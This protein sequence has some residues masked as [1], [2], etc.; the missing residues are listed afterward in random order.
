MLCSLLCSAVCCVVCAVWCVVCACYTYVL[1]SLCSMVCAVYIPQKYENVIFSLCC[2]VLC[3]VCVNVGSDVLTLPSRYLSA[4]WGQGIYYMLCCYVCMYMVWCGACVR[5]CFCFFSL[6][7]VLCGVV[8]VI[9]S[10][11]TLL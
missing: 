4:G 6:L 11:H 5:V 8:R 10:L 1:F 7:L 9:Y 3:G 2:Y